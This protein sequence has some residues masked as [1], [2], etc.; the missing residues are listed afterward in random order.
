MIPVRYRRAWRVLPVFLLLSS[1]LF[2]QEPAVEQAEPQAVIT[3]VTLDRLFD[4]DFRGEF[5]GATRWL[6]DGGGYTTLEAAD[7]AGRDL[8][9]YDTQSGERQV[10]V[11]ASALIPSG[12]EEPLAMQS[13]EWSSDG[14][15]LLI[16]TN[17]RRVWRNNTRGDYWVLDRTSGDLTQLGDDAPE[18]SL[19]F[20][21]FD[22]AGNRV[23]Y[24]KEFDLYVEDLR[25]GEIVRLTAD[26]S[27]TTINGTTDWV[28]E[29]EFSL[30]DGFRWSPDGRTIAFWQLDAEGVRDYLMINDTDSLYSHTIPV[31]Y[32]KAGG[33]NSA[34]RVGLVPAAGGDITWIAFPGDP[35]EHYIPRMEWAGGSD[36]VIIQ[37]MNR[38]QSR[39]QVVLADA[40]TGAL[41]SLFTERDDA[42]LDVVDDWNWL[43]DGRRFLWVSERTGYRHVYSVPRD[44][45]TSTAITFGDYD[46]ISVSLVDERGGWLYF[47]A[48]PDNA[49]QRYLY[50]ARLDG[51][52]PAERVTPAGQPGTH[53]YNISPDGRWALHTWSRF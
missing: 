25:S 21:K 42:W 31:Q 9:L 53:R 33:T 30:R 18:A 2:A 48:S 19:M 4:G 44:G 36:A 32:P 52:S 29:E 39:N 24:R 43:D 8:V 50:R 12:G 38:L 45:S 35:R 5:L 28:Y 14:R 47:M 23:A 41:T 11:P 10:L 37:R 13:Y 6:D 40:G 27:R 15:K 34:A 49:T 1:P 26:G 16:F 7:D 3:D 17:T 20:A 22:P 46:V 51:R